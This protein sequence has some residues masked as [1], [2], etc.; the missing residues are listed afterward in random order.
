[1]R[2]ISDTNRNRN[3]L[4]CFIQLCYFY[5]KKIA[6]LYVISL[7]IRVSISIGNPPIFDFIKRV[8]RQNFSILVGKPLDHQ[9][10]LS[11]NFSMNTQFVDLTELYKLDFH[12]KIVTHK[13]LGDQGVCHTKIEK[14]YWRK[15]F[16]MRPNIDVIKQVRNTYPMNF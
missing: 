1:M 9:M 10:L 5:S 2:W 15:H 4:A 8:H 14:F 11:D 7:L 16:R 12:K 3:K 6:Q 13:H